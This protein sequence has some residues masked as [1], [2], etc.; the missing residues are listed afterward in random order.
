MPN[1][2]EIVV[3]LHGAWRFLHFD[4]RAILL[5]D[6]SVAG[7]W[8]SFFAAFLALPGYLLLMY[9]V[10]RVDPDRTPK[11]G[12]VVNFGVEIV[13][14]ALTW[15][16]YP[17]VMVTLSK[18]MGRSD[19]YYAYITAHNWSGVIYFYVLLPVILS[20]I[21]TGA[22]GLPILLAVQAVMLAYIWFIARVVLD[23]PRI[24]ATLLVVLE[25]SISL[26]FETLRVELLGI[27]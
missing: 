11:V 14:F 17:I 6:T 8:K 12:G 25:F 1:I 16:S 27:G 24:S 5:F 26:I 21:L 19:R 3:G 22:L 9:L 23:I 15:I 13:I 7:F 4:R 20:G 2:Q 18:W 10:A